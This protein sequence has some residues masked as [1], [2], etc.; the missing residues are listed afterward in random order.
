MEQAKRKLK[1]VV[2]ENETLNSEVDKLRQH[3]KTLEQQLREQSMENAEQHSA[4]EAAKAKAKSREQQVFRKLG[5]RSFAPILLL[6]LAGVPRITPEWV[7]G[8]R[9]LDATSL[10]QVQELEAERNEALA[11]AEKLRAHLR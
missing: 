2:A 10:P 6:S 9:G 1:D 8:P 3:N 11:E 5:P 7:G 4:L